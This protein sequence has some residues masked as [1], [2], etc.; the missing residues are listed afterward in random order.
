MAVA[1]DTM[2]NLQDEMLSAMAYVARMRIRMRGLN[3]SLDTGHTGLAYNALERA[4][5][6]LESAHGHL[7]EMKLR[8]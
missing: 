6:E 7:T 8:P 4:Q 3:I 2:D 1:N 5:K